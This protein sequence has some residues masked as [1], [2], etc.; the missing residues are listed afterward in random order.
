MNPEYEKNLEAQIERV[1]KE[2]PEL[3]APRNLTSRVLAAIATRTALPWYRQPL[4]AWPVPLRIATMIFLLAAFGGLCVAS[5]E[6]TRA[7]GF[8]NAMQEIGRSFS[9]LSSIWNVISVLLNAV[10]LIIKHLGTGFIVGCCLAAAL[11]YAVCVGL[12]TA[13]VR[14]AYARK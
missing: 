10:V 5:F 12:G 8:T 11:G 1:L 6:L 7:A 13:C 3:N 14:L 4:L 9:G 2:L